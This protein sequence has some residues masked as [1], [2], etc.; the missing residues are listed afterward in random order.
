MNTTPQILRILPEVI[1]TIT[2]VLIMLA[3]PLIAKGKSRRPL[4]WLAVIGTMAALA[5]SLYQYQL[6]AGTAFFGTVKTDAF[7]VFFHVLICCI[8]LVCLLIT[9]DAT[10]A[11]TDGM[12]E[13]YALIIFGTVGMLF[14]TCAVELLLVFIGLEISSI[15]TYILAGFRK[16]TAKGPESAIKYFLLGSFA[17]AFFLYGIALTFGATGTTKIEAIA[18]LLTVSPTPKLAIAGLAMILIGLAF[19]VSAAP[20]QVWTPDVYEGSPSPVVA[21]MSTAPKAAAFAVLLRI[22]YSAFPEMHGHWVPLLWWL[23]VLSMFV[24][25]LGALRQKNVK[26]MLAY[27]SIAHAGYLLVAFTAFSAEGIAAASFYAVTYAAMNVGI[28]AVI[29]HVGGYEDRL[30]QVDDYRGLAY[31]S[32]L[33]GGA[34]AF[35]LF[36]LIGIPFTGGF[37]GKFYVFTAAI[38]S[39]YVWLAILGLINSGIAAFYYLRVV[40]TLYTKPKESAPVA[41]IPRVTIPLLFA[42]L[43]TVSATLILGV[44]PGRVLAQARAAANATFAPAA[45]VQAAPATTVV[46]AVAKK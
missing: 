17:T 42:L 39:G 2:G 37:F 4:G 41:A 15:S 40:T 34:M 30:T 45:M 33:L 28:F 26:R 14:M 5:A 27:S 9:L 36:S 22:L 38:H 25:N 7:S 35:F 16:H 20:F 44:V 31:R 10:T 46:Q 12:G 8:S 29:S 19:K 11:K 1:L 21:L 3:E 43:C 32:P 23:A 13:F 18:H 24:G 6:P